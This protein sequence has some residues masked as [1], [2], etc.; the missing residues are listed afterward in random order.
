MKFTETEIEGVWII[1]PRVFDDDRGYFFESFNAKNFEEATGIQ[2]NFV[3]DNQSFSGRGVLRGMH[4]QLNP[5]SQAKLV[6]VL[7]GE[8]QDVAVDIRK[9]SPTFGKYVSVILNS[10]NRKQ[11]YIPRG[12]AHGFLVLSKTAVF[13]YKCDNFYSKSDEGGLLYNDPT[14]NIKWEL[15]ESEFVLSEKDAV[16]P[17]LN[18][19]LNNFSF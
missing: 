6:Q 5:M 15:D 1:E 11:L 9:G 12:F 18:E 17:T 10:E 8:V 4:Y 14:V 7:E 13:A 16:S 3:Q 19:A 2:P